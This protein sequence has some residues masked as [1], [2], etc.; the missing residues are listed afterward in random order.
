MTAVTWM[1]DRETIDFL[2]T[3]PL[4]EGRDEADLVLPRGP[5]EQL[6]NGE[7]AVSRVFLDVIQRELVASLRQTLRQHARLATSV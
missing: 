1:S 6:L 7:D 2:A 4:L 3:V 5:F